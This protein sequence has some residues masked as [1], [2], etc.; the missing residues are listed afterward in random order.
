[1]TRFSDFSSS[2]DNNFNLLR[3][4]AALMVIVS[5]SYPLSLGPG[6]EQPLSRQT[7]YTLGTFGVFI[8]FIISGYLITMSRAH[9]NTP[10]FVLARAL[11]IFPAILVCTLI[12]AFICGPF[13]TTLRTS[14][15]FSNSS[16]YLFILKNT[17][18]LPFTYAKDLPGVF[19]SNPFNDSFNGSLWTLPVELR[20]YVLI[21]ILGSLHLLNQ[22]RGT[23]VLAL[24]AASTVFAI[25]IGLI[26][27]IQWK[28]NALFFCGALFYL[29]RNF[30]PCSSV[31]LVILG[32][33]AAIASGSPLFLLCGTVFL[34]YAVLW[35]GYVPG[36]F[37]RKFNLLGDY[38]YGLYIYAFPV[39]QSVVYFKPGIAPIELCL[40]STAVTLLL[41]MLSWHTIE[42]PILGLKDR[43]SG[44]VRRS[45]GEQ[46]PEPVVSIA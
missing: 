30:I 23:A 43:L 6:V 24:M 21:G 44:A 4:L 18:F 45:V 36:G 7:G 14:E 32:L 17:L 37:L 22:R 39:Q 34:S 42:K 38:S 15:Y 13:L 3:F 46:L 35:L 29:N 31:V 1:M 16:V 41:A 19:A 5:H 12:S 10:R 26:H 11:R 27:Q 9:S 20:L 33:V 28:L 25:E 40:I 8:F 2:R